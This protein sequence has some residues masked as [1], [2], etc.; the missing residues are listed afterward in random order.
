MKYWNPYL[1]TLSRERLSEIELNN[2]RK[3]LQYAKGNSPFYRKRYK[4]IVPEDIKTK[5]DLRSLPLLDKEDLRAAQEG[6]EP[7]L[8][9]EI[10][11]VDLVPHPLDG[12]LSGDG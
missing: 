9:G 11:G 2:F 4:D 8:Y 5:E 6:K 3:L 7:S 10:L 1:E 12:G